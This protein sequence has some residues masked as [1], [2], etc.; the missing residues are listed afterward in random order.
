M[1]PLIS[2]IVPVYKVEDVLTRCLDSLCRQSLQNIEILLVDDA[3]PDRCGAICKAYAEKDPRFRVIHHPENRGL[4]AARNTGIAHASANY[5][6][7]VDSDDWVHEDFCKLPY[8][9]AVKNSADLVMFDRLTIDR[10]GSVTVVKDTA[11]RIPGRLTHLEALDLL[12]TKVG[13]TA[14]NKLYKK[15]IFDTISYP[16]GLLYED[17][18]TTYKAILLADAVYFLDKVL[19]FRCYHEGSITTLRTKKALRDWFAMFMQQYHD[20]AAWGYPQ[21]KLELRLQNIALSYCIKK[22][23][24]MADPDYAF[25]RKTLRGVKGI[26]GNFTWR[27][28]I[29]FVLLKYCPPV[30][31][32]VCNLWGK[33]WK[34]I[35]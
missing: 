8:E 25:C 11:D 4:S 3:S 17:V 21:D 12:F 22:K 27:R 31:D 23:E 2:V 30:F 33:R 6:M 26:L 1:C 18:G 32:L 7:F 13:Y 15:K 28:K 10:H 5:I 14:W 9:C 20:L 24:D 35:E 16:D 29:L 34:I 19:Y